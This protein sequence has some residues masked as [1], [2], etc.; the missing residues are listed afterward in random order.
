MI[1]DKESHQKALEELQKLIQNNSGTQKIDELS[2]IIENYEKKRFPIEP[3]TSIELIKFFL[4][5][6]NISIKQLSIECNISENKLNKKINKKDVFT[7]QEI[8]KIFKILNIP[9]EM[10]K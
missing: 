10:I 4:D 6:N 9:A 7:K 3:V 2:L 1:K 8:I 5:Q